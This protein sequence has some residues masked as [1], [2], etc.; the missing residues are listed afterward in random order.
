MADQQTGKLAGILGEF[1]TVDEIMAV[2][3]KVRDAGYIRW[4]SYT[5]FPVHGIDRAMGIKRTLL[6]KIVFGAGLTGLMVG[7]G[8]QYWMN[9]VDYPYIIS[10]KPLFSLPAQIPIIFELV[11]LFSALT[12]FGG[13]LA[14]NG[15]PQLHHPLDSSDAFRRVTTDRFFVYIEAADPNFDPETIE[16]LYQSA[17]SARIEAIYEEE[18]D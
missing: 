13:M 15:L 7:L 2:C 8:M 12:T 5:P 16:R 4:D 11:I 18:E 10:G 3:S 9:A 6:P 17:G 14:L 1:E